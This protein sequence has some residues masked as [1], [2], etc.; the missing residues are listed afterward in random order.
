MRFTAIVIV[1]GLIPGLCTSAEDA[2]APVVNVENAWFT[3]QLITNSDPMCESLQAD[4]KVQFFSGAAWDVP[5]GAAKGYFTGM[6]RLPRPFEGRVESSPTM[7]AVEGDPR[8]VKLLE[9][10]GSVF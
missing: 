2:G 6:T 5:Y 7:Q 3:P 1:M 9:A 10:D 8:K 4:A